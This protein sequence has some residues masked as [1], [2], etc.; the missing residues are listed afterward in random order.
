MDRT[1]TALVLANALSWVLVAAGSAQEGTRS[2]AP[3]G[4]P[5]VRVAASER[6]EAS[7]IHR[8][9]LG[10]GYRD[11]WQAEIE[12]PVLNLQTEGGG[13]VPT[14]RFGGLQT[15]VL[16]FAGEDGNA[17]SFRGTD[18]DPAAVLPPVLRDT[19]I[20]TLVQDQMAAQHPAGP[21]A[22]GVL[23]EAAGVLTV[24]ERMVVM[25]DDPALGQYREEFAGMVGMFFEFPLPASSKRPGFHGAID[26][27]GYEEIYERLERSQDDQVDTEAFLRA[28]LLDILIGD[29]DRHRK[30]WRWAKLPGDSRW[31]PIPEDRDMAFVRYEGVGPK[32][33]KI[34]VPILQDYGPTYPLMKGLTL[35]GWEQDRW[36]LPK[37]SWARWEPIA[38]DM[39]TR[40]TDE[41]IDRAV[42][43]LPPE[44][45]ELDGERLRDAIRGRRDRLLEGARRYYEHLA[46]QV[47]VQATD[48]AEEVAVSRAEDGSMLVEVRAAGAGGGADPL[49]SRR[50]DPDETREVRIFLHD[51]DDRVKVVGDDCSIGLRVIAGEGR[52]LLD[53]SE[54]GGTRLYDEHGTVDVKRG[55]GTSVDRR[56]YEPPEDNAGF[57]DVEGVPPRDWGSDLIPIPEFGYEKD[58]GAFLGAGLVYTRY[59]FRKDPWSSRHRLSAGF[60][61]EASRGRGRYYGSFR[62]ENSNLLTNLELRMSGI[63]ILR[64]YGFG[65]NT[66][67]DQDNSFFRVRNRQYRAAPALEYRMLE[68]KVRVS[69]GPWLEFSKTK[70]GDRLIDQASPYGSGRFGLVGAFASVQLDTR[71]S[72]RIDPDKDLELHENPATGYPISGFLV[73]L[74]SEVSPPLW[75]VKKTWG[76]VEGSV[77][78]FVSTGDQDRVTL[79]LKVGGRTTFGNTPYFKAAYVGGG[80]FFSGGSSVRGLRAERFAGD[81]SVYGNADLRVLVGRAKVIVPT[82]FGLLGFVDVGRVFEDGES[83]RRWHPGAG[84][85]F[86][87][88]PLARSNALSFTVARSEEDTLFYVKMGFAF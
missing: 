74:T 81:H 79:A 30:Q 84:G 7:R 58:V 61:T 45:Q 59:G 88:A 85:G 14:G 86:W 28:R 5:L 22:V 48:E 36:L 51:G 27:I 18:K 66:K 33:G 26:I 24:R 49:F 19:A 76:A 50:F 39:Q 62:F 72:P 20:E 42:A 55:P 82:D 8:F 12:L 2:A 65:N 16:G 77:S 3:A 38:R 68:D 41:V 15:A 69:G 73:D 32:I 47:N 25:P 9:A 52:K 10:G 6:Y 64:F 4:E 37:L 67:D 57:V 80:E 78:A 46:G 1:L 17:Y 11:L 75:G 29:F 44:Y 54:G 34:Y 43:A 83:S 21:L 63:D 87:I 53:D 23:S 71:Q 40:I 35:H 60:A 31:Q 70:N 56:H 13:L